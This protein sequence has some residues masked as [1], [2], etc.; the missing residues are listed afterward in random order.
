MDHPLFDV[1]ERDGK[2]FRAL[3]ERLR[4]LCSMTV[5]EF[6]NNHSK[7]LR[8]HGIDFA[9]GRLAVQ[10]FGMQGRQEVDLDAWQIAISANEHGRVHGFFIGETFYIR[11]LDPEHNLYA[12]K[13]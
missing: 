4:D 1:S 5:R 11:W 3:L 8:I 10:S 6:R 9:D 7:S 2:Y 13:G 12:R